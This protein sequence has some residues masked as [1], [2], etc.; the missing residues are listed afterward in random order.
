MV[1]STFIAA[2][3]AS[4]TFMSILG[5]QLGGSDVAAGIPS[6]ISMLGRAAAGY[7]IGWLMDKLGRRL[8]L[9]LGYTLGILGG[10]LSVVAIGQE[11]LWGFSLG[12]GLAGMCRSTV[13]QARFIAAEVEK[14]ERRAKVIGLIVA[15]GT[16]GAVGGPLLAEPTSWVMA[17]L[18]YSPYTGPYALN[19]VLSLLCL[20]LVF[21]LLRPD[22]LEIGRALQAKLDC[23]SRVVAATG[24]GRS[25]L[26][27]LMDPNIRLALMALL[28]GQFAMTLLMVITPLDMHHHA[29]GAAAISWVIVAHSLGMYA[30]SWCTSWLIDRTGR[31]T[32]IVLGALTLVLAALLCPFSQSLLLLTLSMFFVGLGWNLSFIAGSSLLADALAVN[33]RGRIQGFSETLSALA[34]STGSLSS[35]LAF[36]LGGMVMVG[37]VGLS[38]SVALMGAAFVWGRAKAAPMLVREV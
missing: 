33:E 34:G 11:S 17:N 24:D 26:Q 31:V 36:Q 8:G 32:V 18:G 12:I 7:P 13:E 15:G 22:P 3:V 29:H 4:F 9:S 25:I 6:T 38:L 20:L 2:Q 27:V 35:G 1:Y 28:V 10:V 16:I 23:A 5:A 30:L 19:S 14:P 21:A 37:V